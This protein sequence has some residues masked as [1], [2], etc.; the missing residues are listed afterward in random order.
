MSRFIYADHSATTPLSETALNAMLPWLRE[1][2]GN[3]SSIYSIGRD[4]HAALEKARAQVAGMLNAKPSEIIFTGCGSESDNM[5]LR[6][7]AHARRNRGSHII[8]TAIEHHAMLHTLEAL[9]KEGFEVTLLAPDSEG[10][11]SPA[12]VE[13]AIRPDTILISVMAANEIGTI[14]PIAEIGAVAAAHKIPFHTDAVQAFGHIPL[15][16][17][18]MHIS[19]LSLSAHKLGGPKGVGALYL[20]NGLAA[21]PV[22]YGGGQE[23]GRR[24]GTENV[25]GIVGLG[26]AAEEA[27]ANMEADAAR[28][29][30]LRDRLIAA[31]LEIPYSRLT[32]PRTDRLPGH[33]SFCFEAVEGEA[34]VLTLD[35]LGAAASSGSACSSGSLD[36]SHVLM[37]IGLPQEV[38]HGSLRLTLGPEN[39][40]EDVDTLIGIVRSAVERLRTMS[41]LWDDMRKNQI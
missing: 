4:A 5:A 35:M 39:T 1:G 34:L 16:V 33:A 14:E 28:L 10:F 8:S 19:A 6:G 26:A 2:Y 11:I 18:A 12:D 40:E 38:A 23:R 13:A 3:P 15:D 29:T 17:N 20:K 41:P 25:A 30:A 37:A 22:I 31:L 27:A 24:G 7:I 21:E 9:E 32:G 36:P